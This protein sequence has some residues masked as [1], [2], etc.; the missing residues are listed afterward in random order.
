VAVAAINY[1]AKKMEVEFMSPSDIERSS[2]I[3]KNKGR[4]SGGAALLMAACALPGL[5]P[6]AQ[7]ETI[8]EFGMISA[9][10]LA[11]HQSQPNVDSSNKASVTSP[12]IY[13]SKPIAGQW[14][15]EGSITH[16]KVSGASP[17][18]HTTAASHMSDDRV[19][20]DVKV[21]RYFDH[22][23]VSLGAAYSTEHD[24]KSTAFSLSGTKSS[25]DNNTTWSGGVAYNQDKI[26]P[27]NLVVVNEGKRGVEL[28][29]GVTQVLTPLD[30]A[31]L[32]TTYT[33]G[34]GYY[35]DPYKTF[36][37][38]PRNRSANVLLARWNHHLKDVGATTRASYRYYTD[39]FG[40]K[41][42]TLGLEVVKTYPN[43]W[44]VTPAVR[45]STQSKADFYYDPPFPNGRTADGY[46]TADQRLAN[47]GSVTVG[48]KVSKQIDA[49]SSIDFKLE[50]YAQRTDLYLGSNKSTG[51]DPLRA[52]MLQIGYSRKF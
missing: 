40:V 26:N 51:L 48:L 31:Q 39:T 20:A 16:D 29:V 49:E 52:T 25:Q 17:R 21:K 11:Y 10:L 13:I 36:D 44:T 1:K 23:T 12:S 6:V 18:Y 42:H 50:S 2:Q 4:L 35:S 24:Y 30:I 33:E 7:A 38:R 46:Y 22:A 34:V 41:A 15:V 5:M 45:Y 32:N 47:M 19:A 14:L 37:K 8:P 3:Q 28:Q 27:T 9:K 43:G